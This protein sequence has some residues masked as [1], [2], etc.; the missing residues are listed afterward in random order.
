MRSKAKVVD[1]N[2]E[3]KKISLSIKALLPEAP[4]SEEAPAEESAE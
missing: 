1:V 3:E 4:E 2:V